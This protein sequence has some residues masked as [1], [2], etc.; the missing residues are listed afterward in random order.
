MILKLTEV[1]AQAGDCDDEVTLTYEARQK[2]RLRSQTDSGKEIGLFLPRGKVLRHG[3]ILTGSDNYRIRVKSASEHLSVVRTQDAWQFARACYHL[4]NRHVPLQILEGELRFLTDYVLDQMI[5]GL[6]LPVCHAFL[7][8]EPEQG[9]Y[10]S[11][12]H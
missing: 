9:A 7:P 11:H 8:F 12:G 4:G 3:F 2:S 5:E 10:H 6:G 1:T